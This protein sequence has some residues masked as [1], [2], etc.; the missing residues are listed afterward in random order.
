MMFVEGDEMVTMLKRAEFRFYQELNDFLSE[1]HGLW[2]GYEFMGS[3]SV[4]DCVEAIGVPHT[5]IDLILVNGDS[6][7]R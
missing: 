3:P 4:K 2:I 6:V 5:E 7:G 1:G